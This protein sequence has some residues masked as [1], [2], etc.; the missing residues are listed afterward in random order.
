MSKPASQ[1]VVPFLRRVRTQGLAQVAR[2]HHIDPRTRIPLEYQRL[3]WRMRHGV[4]G[5][6]VPVYVVGL[7][8]SGTNMLVRAFQNSVETQVFNENDR[9]AF[10][11]YS[12][13]DMEVVRRLVVASPR[14]V[15]VFKPLKD[16]DRIVDIL[17]DPA[18]PGQARAIW[19]YR[20]F[21][22]RV[23]SSLGQFDDNNLTVLR[24][25]ADGSSGELWQTRFM[26]PR[27]LELVRSLDVGSMN[28]ESAAGLM[29]YLRNTLFFEL[30]LDH[31]DD[32]A[33]VS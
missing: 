16:S 18:M 21:E 6:A 32:V 28:P 22:G 19:A 33:V 12:L 11:V 25:A 27:L 10:H 29:W 13:R 26:G 31:R 20:S 15:V 24:A 14:R 2:D 3:R 8:R 17:E 30:A 9:R 5:Q 23:R 4:A 7:Q 1:K